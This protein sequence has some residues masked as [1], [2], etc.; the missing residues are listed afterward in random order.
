MRCLNVHYSSIIAHLPLD[1]NLKLVRKTSATCHLYIV[2]DF[3]LITLFYPPRPLGRIL[4]R[5]CPVFIKAVPNI[6]RGSRTQIRIEIIEIGRRTDQCAENEENHEESSQS[7]VTVDVAVTDRR[8]RNESEVN[9]IPVGQRVHVGEIVERITRVLHLKHNKLPVCFRQTKSTKS[10]LT[11]ITTSSS[12]WRTPCR[13]DD[14][15]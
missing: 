9:A 8:H 6:E 1:V 11:T 13:T 12:W 14:L 5:F 15:M 2:Q 10:R 7:C 3:T 4:A